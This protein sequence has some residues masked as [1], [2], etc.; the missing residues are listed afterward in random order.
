ML[1]VNAGKRSGQDWVAWVEAKLTVA[2]APADSD[3]DGIPDDK[4]NCPN[5]YNPNQEDAYKDGVGDA[6]DQVPEVPEPPRISLTLTP[7]QPQPGDR[8]KIA[9]TASGERPIQEVIIFLDNRPVGRCPQ[10]DCCQTKFVFSPPLRISAAAIDIDGNVNI[11]D[12]LGSPVDADLGDDDGDGRANSFDNCR[13]ELNAD[14]LDS[15]RDGVGNA[16]DRCDP[17]GTHAAEGVAK[18]WDFVD[19]NGCGC[20]HT[21]DGLA[22]F[23]QGQLRRQKPDEEIRCVRSAGRDDVP[24]VCTGMVEIVATDAGLGE[25][26]VREYY[27]VDSSGEIGYRDSK[28]P[29]GCE[30]GSCIC[31]DADSDGGR[32]YYTQGCLGSTSCDSCLDDYQLLERYRQTA[33][34]E[35]GVETCQTGCVTYDCPIGCQDGACLCQ[36]S[37]GGVN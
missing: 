12:I 27:F 32:R 18:S 34:N 20:D 14:Q 2:A 5:K 9:V 4:D 37:D 6:C 31:R 1:Y 35:R 36:D 22:Y 3:K 7:A 15:G 28:C 29:Y 19:A 11:R 23:T 24:P 25:N 13:H 17:L 10:T 33:V 8:V 16:C 26:R 21:D 30:D